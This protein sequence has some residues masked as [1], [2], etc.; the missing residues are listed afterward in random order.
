MMHISFDEEEK[1]L[2][3]QMHL[4]SRRG[5]FAKLGVALSYLFGRASNDGAWE[6]ILINGENGG[7]LVDAAD[8]IR[9]DV[10]RCRKKQVE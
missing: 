2:E 8:K 6:H 4:A 5:F 7:P 3:V 10:E 9:D 1:Y